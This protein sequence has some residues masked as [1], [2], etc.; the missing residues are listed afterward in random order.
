MQQPVNA[1][2]IH[3]RTVVGQVLDDTLDRIAFLQILEQRLA[4]CRVLLLD[5]RAA[6]NN[7]IISPL[8]QFD[9]LEFEALAFEITWVAD[10]ANVDQRTRQECSDVVDF[11]RESTL[12]PAIDNTFDNLAF[13]ESLL[14]FGPGACADRFF[15]RQARF[16]EAVFN[17]IQ[18]DLDLIADGD[19]AVRLVGPELFD[20][21]NGLRLEACTDDDDIVVYS[22]NGTLDDGTG[23]YLLTGKT[24]F[25]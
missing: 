21:D 4:L 19:S 22:N 12:D 14:E 16:A 5:D 25:K 8:I 6:R 2:E 11:D 15:P 1:A 18:R 13:L 17:G 9:Y 3:E 24:F 10:R 7:D 23:L 20:G